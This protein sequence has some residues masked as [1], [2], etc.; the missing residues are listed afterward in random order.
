MA[1]LVAPP[2]KFTHPEWVI[3]NQTQYAN[4]EAE[5]AAAE[6]LFDESGR[7]IEETDGRTK[8]TQAD[9]NKKLDQ[10]INDVKYWNTEVDDKLDEMKKE[11]EALD[12]FLARIDNAILGCKEPLHIAEACLAKRRARQNIELVH[13]ETEKH[14]IKEMEVLHGVMELLAR[15]KEQTVE[16][17]RLNRKAE[18]Q[19]E[20]DLGDKFKAMSIDKHNREL[21]DHSS[22]IRFKNGAARIEGH[23]TDPEQWQSFSRDNIEF[24][25]KQRQNSAQLRSQIDNYLQAVANDLEKQTRD[26]NQAYEDRIAEV[27]QA[28]ERLEEHLNKVLGQIREMEDNQRRLEK[29]IS[30]KENPLKLAE[31]RLDYRTERPNVENCRDSAQYRL[32]EEVG[33]LHA[34]LAALHDSRAKT[35]DSLKALKRRKLELEEDIHLKGEALC[36][37]ESECMAMRKSIHYQAY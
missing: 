1:R 27:R 5:R 30:E 4:A 18:R 7:L 13:D 31:T 3:S 32:V 8:R 24:T 15:L 22:E 28:K 21:T 16:Q 2:T 14:Q 34:S 19:L 29:A 6:R 10:R 23:T 20:R 37:D 9:V 25:E 36:I 12:A 26:T 35:Q 33:E 17:L 11:T